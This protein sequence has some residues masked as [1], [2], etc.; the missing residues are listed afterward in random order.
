MAVEWFPERLNAAIAEAFARSLVLAAADANAASPTHKARA[1]V[2]QTSPTNGVLRATGELGPIMEEG[3]RPHPETGRR[4]FLYLKGL[5]RYVSGT[6][7]H[8][9]TPA[10]PYIRPAAAR[11][12]HGEF[13]AVARVTLSSKG[14]R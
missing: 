8:P 11:W 14:F 2:R 1:E 4:G 12:S 5:N 10:Q 6:I 13:N 7:H 3:G 9:G